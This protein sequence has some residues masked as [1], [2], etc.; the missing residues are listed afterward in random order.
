M[1]I[2]IGVTLTNA[3]R[4]SQPKIFS[5]VASIVTTKKKWL[6]KIVGYDYEIIYN[7]GCYN[8]VVDSLLR[9]FEDDNTL[10]SISLP[11]PNWIE[12]DGK[13]WFLRS[14][15]SQLINNLRVDLNSSVGYSLKDEILCYKD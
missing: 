12:E 7:K 9:Q 13:E 5:I 2:L 11:I 14:S 8:V 4:S 3:H 10:L 15:L 1:A 6:A